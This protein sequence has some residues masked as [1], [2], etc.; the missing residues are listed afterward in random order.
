MTIPSL[1]SCDILLYKGKGFTSWLI[2]VF[3]GSDYNHVAVVVDPRLFLAIE[4]NTGHQSG[5]RALDLRQLNFKEI[6]IFRVKSTDAYDRAEAVSYLVGRL[7]SHYDWAGVIWLGLLKTL[8]LLT[9]I[10]WKP[11]NYFQK[12]K[13][14]FC[15]ELVYEAFA[16]AGLDIVPQV[17]AADITSPGDIAE[18]PLIEKLQ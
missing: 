8:S 16:K 9:F 18:S 3:T 13:D 2:Q 15:S 17:D 10:T 4:S 12:Q 5:V 1:K 6:D 7:G 14:Y 11:F